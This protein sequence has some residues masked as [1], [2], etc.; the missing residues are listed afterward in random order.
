MSQGCCPKC[1]SSDLDY[2]AIEVEENYHYYPFKCNDC[3][4]WG[5]EY[6]TH[7]YSDSELDEEYKDKDKDEE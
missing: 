1:D 4:A 5:K 7:E 6:Y 3:K 2:K